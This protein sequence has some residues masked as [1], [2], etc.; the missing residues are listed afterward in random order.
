MKTKTT[1]AEIATHPA[2]SKVK[3]KTLKLCKETIENLS[4]QDAASVK[5]GGRTTSGI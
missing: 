3:L 1:K 5:G 4:D 2:K